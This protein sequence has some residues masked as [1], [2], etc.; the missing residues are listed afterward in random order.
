[1]DDWWNWNSIDGEKKSPADV[2]VTSFASLKD[3]EDVKSTFGTDVQFVVVG[4]LDACL[5]AGKWVS[6]QPYWIAPNEPGEPEPKEEEPVQEPPKKK[7]RKGKKAIKGEEPL[8]DLSNQENSQEEE[9]EA[10]VEN[11]VKAVKK[12]AAVID[13]H[14]P[15]ASQCHVYAQGQDVYGM[16]CNWDNQDNFISKWN[17]R[18]HAQSNEYCEQLQQVLCHPIAQ[19]RFRAMLLRL[20]EVFLSIDRPFF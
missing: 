1:M 13:H 10:R 12:G 14:C 17:D 19:G 8:A 15:V 6:P 5:D 11:I 18:L 9:E 2:Y 3:P 16:L 20:D 7:S 4:F